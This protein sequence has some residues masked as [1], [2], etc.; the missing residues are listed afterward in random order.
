MNKETNKIVWI[1]II[2]IVI[3][4]GGFWAYS[5]QQ[6]ATPGTTVDTKLL[7]NA[8]SHSTDQG[9][10]TYPV[11]IV[12]FGDY[13]CPAC[14]Y[15]EPIIEKILAN[16]PEVRLVFRNFPL[17]QHPFAL[18]AA[19]AA[20]AAGAQ[21]KFWEMHNAIYANQD[22]WTTMQTPLD[23]FTEI[24]KKLGLDINK[25]TQD[26]NS[27]KYA[28]VIQKDQADGNALLVNSTPTFYIN[29]KQYLKGLDYNTMQQTIQ[30][31]LGA[32]ATQQVAATQK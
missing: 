20:E 6:P 27:K 4:G 13:E 26:V 16:D 22:V 11:T 30:D 12:E 18:L 5:A 8:N 24:A 29:G 23:A 17:Q 25:F 31:A 14:G 15:A 9:T 7:M 32:A 28:D 21:G 1:A 2:A 10:R 19:E 3:I